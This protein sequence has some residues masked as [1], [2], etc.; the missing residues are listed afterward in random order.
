MIIV[1]T[2]KD[3]YE[4]SIVN[5]LYFAGTIR[6]F[7]TTIGLTFFKNN[8]NYIDMA[9]DLGYQA[10]DIINEAINLMNKEIA[11][12]VLANDVYITPYTKDLSLL[13]EKLFDINLVID[14][15]KESAVL[16]NKNTVNY[17]DVIDRINKL[18]SE[19]LKLIDDFKEFVK[20]IKDKLDNGSL[21]SYLY[22]DFFNYMFDEISVYGRDINRIESKNDYT[23]FY[24]REFI[25]YFNELL[26]ESSKYLR[27]FLDT[28]EGELFDKASYFVNAFAALTEKYL[29]SNNKAN[30][31]I[32]TKKLVVDYKDFI[33]EIINNLLKKE[34]YLIIPPITLDNFLTNANV[35]LFI[36]EYSSNLNN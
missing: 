23:A 31:S 10:T 17:D 29:K 2:N 18:N 32:E 30:L 22:P 34:I 21:F 15:D 1:L 3:I 12:E 24:L 25:Y 33:V 27:G 28:S 16:K 19:S 11:N 36:L 35:Y 9:I 7:C 5:H 6:S 8:Q 4:Q 13:T 26:R 14:V 20:E